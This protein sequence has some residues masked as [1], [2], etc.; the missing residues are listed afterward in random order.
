MDTRSGKRFRS[1]LARAVGRVLDGYFDQRAQQER[2]ATKARH[3]ELIAWMTAFE[4]RQRRDVYTAMERAAANE[5]AAFAI[6]AF[7]DARPF[8]HPHDTLRNA[9][10]Q[11][12]PKGLALE[13]GVATGRTLNV[14]ARSRGQREVFGFDSFEGLPEH[15]RWGF[16]EGTFAGKPPVVQGATVIEGMFQDVL[17][18]FLKKHG[19]KLAVAHIDSDLYSAAIYVLQQL[20]PR[21]V[22]GTVI[23]F[24]EYYNFPGWRE[25][26]FRAW[27]EFV[28]ETGLEYEYLGATADDEQVS[29]RITAPPKPVS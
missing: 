19:G 20:R 10:E 24:D 26:E 9:V 15:W 21:M 7:G 17:P 11:S 18:G 16:E 14:M 3:D 2:E 29:V 8:F 23:I 4:R 27:Q 28:A 1:T 22:E 12:P 5:S 13:F 6:E 25:H